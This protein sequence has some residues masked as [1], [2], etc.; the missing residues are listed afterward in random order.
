MSRFKLNKI[1]NEH[2]S[3]EGD[4]TFSTLDKDSIKAFNFLKTEKN[5]TIDLIGI[6]N[7]DS[8][9]LAFFI[10]WLRLCQQHGTSFTPTNIPLQLISLAELSGLNLAQISSL[11]T[12]NY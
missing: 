6:I 9:G 10:E 5:V 8:A 4:L 7:A 11:S 3:I 12:K 1:S 2:Y